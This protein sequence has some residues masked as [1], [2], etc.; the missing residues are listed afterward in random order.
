LESNPIGVLLTDGTMAAAGQTGS[1]A[2][3]SIYLGAP[4]N[5]V[6][7]E[8]GSAGAPHPA[9]YGVDLLAFLQMLRT[10]YPLSKIYVAEYPE[11][12]LVGDGAAFNAVIESTFATWA[13]GNS[14]LLSGWKTL[15]DNSAV[16]ASNGHPTALGYNQIVSYLAPIMALTPPIP[17]ASFTL[18]AN[19][20]VGRKLHIRAYP[21]TVS[22]K[23][24][25]D[26]IT[27]TSSDITKATVSVKDSRSTN[28]LHDK[29][30]TNC[31]TT[32][33]RVNGDNGYIVTITG[34]AAGTATITAMAGNTV[35][36]VVA[37]TIENPTTT[38]I[39]F[40]KA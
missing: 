30:N 3:I 37:L 33:E 35:N 20:V 27:W 38:Q 2:N 32:L 39:L 11:P 13:D 4:I 25:D 12:V 23:P 1:D 34:V 17:P 6:W 36:A 9:Q 7:L 5:N 18:N 26:V 19:V 31:P 29:I 16:L 15:L 22:G 21:C 24:V 10:N 14:V 28:I 8:N 40:Y